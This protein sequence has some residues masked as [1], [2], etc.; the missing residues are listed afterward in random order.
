MDIITL[1]KSSLEKAFRSHKI[2]RAYLFG[3]FASGANDQES[4]VDFL[5]S[6]QEGLEPET[7]GKLWWEL[8][9]E[10]KKILGKEVDILTES[11]LKNPYFIQEINNTKKLIYG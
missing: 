5:V 1:K 10:L 2:E 11:S 4:D 7:K 3:S 8:Y 9:D 6:F